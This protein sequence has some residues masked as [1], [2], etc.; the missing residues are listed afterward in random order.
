MKKM[1]PLWATTNDANGSAGVLN[2]RNEYVC[3]YLCNPLEWTSYYD[4]SKANYAV[5][6]PSIELYMDAYNQWK[7]VISSQSSPLNYKFVSGETGYRVGSGGEYYMTGTVSYTGLNS[8]DS[9]PDNTNIFVTEDKFF[10][11]ASPGIDTS[12]SVL[13]IRGYHNAYVD[14]YYSPNT[15][16]IC[17]IVSLK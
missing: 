4:G 2:Q 6:S 13:Y 3:S 9:G 14:S 10:W 12:G 17:P 8:I 7:G 16:G 1:N 5:G 11:L 15:L